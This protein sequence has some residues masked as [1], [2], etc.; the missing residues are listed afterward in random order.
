MN[1][2]EFLDFVDFLKNVDKYEQRVK[3]LQDENTRLEDNIRLTSEIA[4]IPRTKELT[5]KLLKEA[6]VTLADAKQEAV[7]IKEKAKATYDKRL[8]DLVVRETSANAALAESQKVFKEATTLHNTLIAD[9]KKQLADVS[10]K[11]DA[12]DK[13][14]KEVDERLEKL[15]SVMG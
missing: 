4:D 14:Q 7:D 8:S 13:A 3:I 6:D 5:A 10:V 11:S 15:K 1:I 12:L 9:L 2:K